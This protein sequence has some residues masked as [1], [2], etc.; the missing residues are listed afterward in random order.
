M[1]DTDGKIKTYKNP[2]RGKPVNYK[3]YVPQ[4]QAEGIEPEHY[5]GAVVPGGTQVA[6][7]SADNPRGSKRP[8]LRQPYAEATA[9]PIGKGPVPNVGNNMEHTWSSVDGEIVDDLTGETFDFGTSPDQLD[10]SEQIIDNNDFVSEQALGYQSGFTAEDIQGPL[11]RGNVVIE[12][13]P[14]DVRGIYEEPLVEKLGAHSKY[15]TVTEDLLSIVADLTDDL[16]LL[17]VTGVPL[18]SG[19]KEEIEDQAR[20]LIF[21]EHEMCDGN[22]IPI[23]DIIILKRV[24]V[25][26]GLFLE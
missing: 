22:P 6:R 20:A 26:V 16:Y 12:A 2:E 5:R 9:S 21:G 23:D 24:K 8:A 25:K 4:Y 7:P 17:I 19:P 3:P 10:L 14:A 13:L 18:C 11:Q 1:S 15:E